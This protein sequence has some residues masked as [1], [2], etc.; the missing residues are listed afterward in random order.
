MLNKKAILIFFVTLFL[1]GCVAA[2]QQ[3]QQLEQKQLNKSNCLGDDCLLINNLDYPVEK[4]GEGVKNALIEAIVDEYK[5]WSTYDKIIEKFGNQRPFIMIIRAEEQHISSLKALFDKYGIDI[6]K[7]EW[8]TKIQVSSSLKEACSIGVEAEIAN[9]SLY[10]K[11]LIPAVENYP[12][13]VQVFTSLMNASQDKHLP[14]F[15]K[16]K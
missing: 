2:N 15:E 9:A 13:M 1:T 3:D 12:D 16:C 4:I 6:P 8:I 7:N 10:K 14:A 11:K 5:A